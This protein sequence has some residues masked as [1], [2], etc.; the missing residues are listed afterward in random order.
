MRWAHL[1]LCINYTE[2]ALNFSALFTRSCTMNLIRY[3]LRLVFFFCL[4]PSAFCLLPS[5]FCLSPFALHP[6]FAQK[7][8]PH[9]FQLLPVITAIFQFLLRYF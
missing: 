8:N 5:A 6:V 2:S 9:N 3:M 7:L 1:K 4:L